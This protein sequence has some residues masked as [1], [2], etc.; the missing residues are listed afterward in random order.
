[1]ESCCVRGWFTAR[2]MENPFD[3]VVTLELGGRRRVVTARQIA[4]ELGEPGIA[5]QLVALA[6]GRTAPDEPS[7][8]EASVEGHR[9]TRNAYQENTST[10]TRNANEDGQAANVIAA[11]DEIERVAAHLASAL[12]DEKSI[13][14]FR[15]VAR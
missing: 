4:H 5:V 15:V 12:R 7:V 10:R 13:A 1:M 8:S 9:V 2:A 11:A 6:M 3:L 14:Y